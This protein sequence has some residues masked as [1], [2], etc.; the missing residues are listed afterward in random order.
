MKNYQGKVQ[1]MTKDLRKVN[2]ANRD[3][4]EQI[5][6]IN[7]TKKQLR[8]QETKLEDRQRDVVTR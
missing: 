1:Q 8:A 3:L 5:N 7:K 6:E 4:A 2:Q